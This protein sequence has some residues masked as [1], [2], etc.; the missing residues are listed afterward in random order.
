MQFTK[1][2]LAT[3]AL[4]ASFSASAGAQV[5]GS[6]VAGP[7]GPFLSLGGPGACTAGS[8]CS[9]GGIGSIVGG[10][11]FNADQ[12]FA[13]IPAGSVYESL[14]LSSG[15]SSTSPSRIT[16]GSGLFNI[17]FLWGS[18]DSYNRLQIVA[19]GPAETIQTFT[20]ADLLIPG[21]GDQNF[22]QY[23]RFDAQPGYVITELIFD[24]SPSTDAFEV[25]NFSTFVEPSVVPEPGSFALVAAGLLGLLGVAHRQRARRA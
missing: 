22:S 23:V 2:L 15:P 17:G 8:P 20:I 18:P 4:V 14:F 3:V 7:I 24:N 5:T 21:G 16:F 25:A 19:E 9:L 12:P 13:D 6:K 10:T 11:I 1:S